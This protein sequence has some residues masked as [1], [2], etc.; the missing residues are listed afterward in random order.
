MA[1][2]TE[3]HGDVGQAVMGDVK[4]APRLKNVVHVNLTSEHG[5]TKPIT[6]LQRKSIAA[7]V[8]ELV[9]IGDL[10][11]LDVY[12]VILN[13]F[14]AENIAEFPRDRYKDVMKLLDDWIFESKGDSDPPLQRRMEDQITPAMS[15]SLACAACDKSL[16]AARDARM[17]TVM[18]TAL[19]LVA[20]ALLGWM[21]WSAPAEAE[22]A[23]SCHA[24]GKAYSVGS[25]T[26]MVNGALR[27][28]MAS[29]NGGA[30]YWGTP[31]KTGVR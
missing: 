17:M 1:E 16:K 19:I 18:Q 15:M 5:M 4:E 25:A 11:P 13:D 14:G 3:F 24:E 27:E 26:K 7:K 6:N 10:E 20:T 8:K 21:I 23:T 30:P 12:R 28:C 29:S 2:K 9:E 31:A 22:T